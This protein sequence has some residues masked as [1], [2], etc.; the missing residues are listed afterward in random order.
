M[1]HG[2]D[3]NRPGDP[4]EPPGQFPEDSPPELSGGRGAA[5]SLSGEVA[6]VQRIED[7]DGRPV[8]G[9][10]LRMRIRKEVRDPE[11]PGGR[12]VSV[13]PAAWLLLA[14]PGEADLLRVVP[15]RGADSVRDAFGLLL[16][17]EVKRALASGAKVRR[18]GTDFVIEV[19]DGEARRLHAR[20]NVAA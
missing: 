7:V 2:S 15:A 6:H 19:D 1:P 14:R 5:V 3:Q 16:P 9:V 8:V 17:A 20:H 11:R 13:Y 18:E 4:P 12:F 10:L